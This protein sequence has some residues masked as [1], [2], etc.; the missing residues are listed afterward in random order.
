MNPLKVTTRYLR[1]FIKFMRK[2]GLVKV[3]INQLARSSEF[4]GKVVVVT[5][6]ASGL[7]FSISKAFFNAGAIVVMIGRNKTHLQNAVKMFHSDRAI[8]YCWDFDDY[9]DGLVFSYRP[10]FWKTLAER[11]PCGTRFFSGTGSSV[12]TAVF[13]RNHHK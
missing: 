5:G 2:G 7:G 12:R 4:Q 1:N 6:G 3:Q 11:V 9:F 10:P 13:V 8:S